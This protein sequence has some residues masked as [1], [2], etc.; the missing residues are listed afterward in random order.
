[1]LD[2]QQIHH[3]PGQI[4]VYLLSLLQLSITRLQIS[5][6][7]RLLVEQ[8]LG[9]LQ[10]FFQTFNFL[11]DVD[12]MQLSP[13]LASVFRPFHASS[14]NFELQLD[15]IRVLGALGLASIIGSMPHII[16]LVRQP[17]FFRLV[18]LASFGQFLAQ[19]LTLG[20]LVGWIGHL[21]EFLGGHGPGLG[22][23]NNFWAMLLIL[24]LL[25]IVVSIG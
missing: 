10:L 1:M 14:G 7:R 16:D 3:I 15:P 4:Q 23:G 24:L 13:R 11:G 5:H 8:L 6:F 21:V 18:R 17:I 9:M 2:N 19:L 25:L 20:H 22:G 12:F